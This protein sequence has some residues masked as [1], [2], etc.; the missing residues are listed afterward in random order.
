LIKTDK[1]YNTTNVY[2]AA[3]ERLTFLFNNFDNICFSFSGG[4]DSSVTVQ[5]GAKVA[6]KLKKKFSVMY[7][8]LEAMFEETTKHVHDVKES[9]K[10]VCSNFYWVC[11]PIV[12]ENSLSSL[13]PEF[14]TWDE[15]AKDVWVRNMPEGAINL[16]NNPFPFYENLMSFE[17]FVADY[18]KWFSSKS[19]GVSAIVVGIRTDES[20]RRFLAIISEG[21]A[22]FQDKKW[23]TKTIEKLY[24]VYPIYDWKVKDIWGAV[25]KDD[26]LYNKVYD[27]MW[28]NGVPLSRQRICQPF[29]NAQKAGIDQFKS[30]EPNTWEKLLKRVTGVNFGAIYCR[31]SLLGTIK[32]MKPKHMTWEQYAV[33]LLESIGMYEP[34]IMQRYYRKIKYYLKWEEKNHNYPYGVVPEEP[35][36]KGHGSWKNIA[37]GI[38][39][40]DF[41]LTHMSFG[42]DTAGDELLIELRKKHKLLGEGRIQP[43]IAKKIES[44]QQEIN[45]D[46]TE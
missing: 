23:T 22:T 32:S 31:T 16:D 29:G 12:E 34:L 19:K 42:I 9:I 15:S 30:I 38:E 1:I 25:A 24:S 20:L 27:Y 35:P 21:K 2:D 17:D 33:F 39:K 43:K 18:S 4:K 5:L 13:N 45:E 41:F 14:I 3:I 7:L 10:D 46:E 28:K 44:L 37:R 6:R 40:N 26:L 11:L 36:E 8:D